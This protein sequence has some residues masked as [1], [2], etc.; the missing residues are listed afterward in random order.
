MN[1]HENEEMDT[2]SVP[3]DIQLDDLL[4]DLINQDLLRDTPPGSPAVPQPMASTSMLKELETTTPP[5]SF[6]NDSVLPPAR[7][8]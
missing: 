4:V 6:L 7:D 2:N 8:S 5:F 3:E 1:N